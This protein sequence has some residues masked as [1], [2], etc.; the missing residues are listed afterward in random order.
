M[1]LPAAPPIQLYPLTDFSGGVNYRAD[2]LELADCETPSVMN[3]D[4]GRNGG[5]SRRDSITAFNAQAAD[6]VPKNIW[7]YA[8]G[9]GTYQVLI[10]NGTA[11][12]YCNYNN[13]TFTGVYVD[14]LTCAGKMRAATMKDLC[15]VQ[16]NA[17]RVAIKW[18]GTTGTTLGVA[19]NDNIAAPTG[20]NMPKAKCIAAWGGYMWVANTVEGANTYKSRIRW[21]H[22]N[23]PGDWRNNDYIDIDIGHDGDEITAIQPFHD[24][25][26]VFKNN[27]THVIYGYDFTTFSAQVVSTQVGAISQ[28]AVAASEGTVYFFSSPDG[29]YQYDRSGLMWSFNRLAPLLVDGS[30]TLTQVANVG[31]G[32]INRRLWVSLPIGQDVFTASVV[33]SVASNAVFVL[34]PTLARRRRYASAAQRLAQEGGWTRYDLKLGYFTTLEVP[35][36]K[37]LWLATSAI[38]ERVIQLHPP[39]W[40][41]GTS[42]Y[43]FTNG[44]GSPYSAPD[45]AELSVT[46]DLTIVVRAAGGWTGPARTLVAKW[47]PTGNQRSYSLSTNAGFP[48]LEWSNNGTTV[49]SATSTEPVPVADLTP[50][51]IRASL[52]VVNGANKTVKFEFSDDGANWT[53]Y[54]PSTITTAGTT[55]IFDSTAKATIGARFDAMTDQSALGTIYRVTI[56]SGLPGVTVDKARVDFTNQT[57]GTINVGDSL[58]LLTWT[59]KTGVA[60]P[61]ASGDIVANYSTKWVDL[62]EPARKKRWRRPELAIRGGGAT[63]FSLDVYRDYISSAAYRTLS[64]S[65]STLPAASESIKK[66]STLGLARAIRLNLKTAAGQPKWVVDAITLKYIPRRIVS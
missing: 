4:L 58:G 22:A 9:A 65:T 40:S 12:A 33:G 7:T 17:E 63:T 44:T 3:I 47:E 1:A 43:T 24:R 39:S 57:R 28:E 61:A 8:N 38:E 42:D 29:V 10:Q 37:P 48:V 15:F 53:A 11:F 41:S 54:T 13:P 2:A 59:S 66:L 62:R 34:D 27:S 20:L 45:S 50:C 51:Y 5:I 46:G 25:L 52:K 19:F 26:L 18:N 64:F 14:G 60:L 56:S 16:R 55:S 32:W 30:I 23:Q 21:S 6:F 31:L 35:N 49:L 36:Q